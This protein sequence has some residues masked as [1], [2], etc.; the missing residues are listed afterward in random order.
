MRRP[1]VRF[2]LTLVAAASILG[3][4]PAT[5]DAGIIPWAWDT[6]FGP[7]GSIQAR[8]ATYHSGGFGGGYDNCN[9]CNGYSAGAFYGPAQPVFVGFRGWRRNRACC[10]NNGYAAN[11]GG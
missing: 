1:A 9:S 4:V 5:S 10:G 11:Y 7:V 6:M 8:H 2:L 3:V